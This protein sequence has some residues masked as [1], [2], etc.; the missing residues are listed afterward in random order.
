M[1]AIREHNLVLDPPVPEWV[2]GAS[3]Y[4]VRDFEDYADDNGMLRQRPCEKTFSAAVPFA[5]GRVLLPRNMLSDGQLVDAG[6]ELVDRV[7][8]VPFIQAMHRHSEHITPRDALQAKAIV[9]ARTKDGFIILGTGKGKTVVMLQAAVES[10]MPLL[11]FFDTN[12]LLQQWYEDAQEL[13]QIPESRL[14]KCL[15]AYEK[16]EWQD[17]WICFTSYQSFHRQTKR[18]VIP[19]EFYRYF[20][21]VAWDEAHVSPTR[22]RVPTLGLFPCHRIGLTATPKRMGLEK[23]MYMHVGGPLVEDVSTDHIP[24]CFFRGIDLERHI[25]PAKSKTGYG[26]LQGHCMGGPRRA[27]DSGYYAGCIDLIRELR[28]RG[29][30]CM[31][32]FDRLR[33]GD[34]MRRAFPDAAVVDRRV[35]YTRRPELLHS[36]D[37]VFFSSKIGEKGMNRKD[38]D[39]L[40]ELFPMGSGESGE[41]RLFQGAGRVLRKG[42][43]GAKER[44]GTEVWVC[45]P[46]NG[47]GGELARG[48]EAMI[49]SRGWPVVVPAPVENVHALFTAS[50]VRENED[51]MSPHA[52]RRA[53]CSK[54]SSKRT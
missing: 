51:L 49:H 21:H 43:G 40:V 35:H 27:G 48:L 5:D 38:L 37:L 6:Y 47:Y 12:G 39:T 3:E 44:S 45:Y 15:G 1:L 18:H 4:L 29:R 33:T 19:V 10:G 7:H 42:I 54:P 26:K 9:L 46:N 36:A 22:T 50:T 14:G 32:L 20:G 11:V 24:N 34:V 52:R 23:L 13:F 17:R 53:A 28:A 2:W 30:K 25:E 16:W 8:R 41:T 31:V